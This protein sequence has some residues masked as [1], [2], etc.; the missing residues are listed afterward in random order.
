MQRAHAPRSTL[1]LIP[2]SAF[3]QRCRTASPLQFALSL[4][5][6]IEGPHFCCFKLY[7][8]NSPESYNS[9]K[10]TKVLRDRSTTVMSGNCFNSRHFA[11]H[12][13][14]P[15]WTY[16]HIGICFVLASASITHGCVGRETGQFARRRFRCHK[17][18]VCVRGLG[19]R[20]TPRRIGTHQFPIIEANC[21]G[22]RWRHPLQPMNNRKQKW[23]PS[24]HPHVTM[25][26]I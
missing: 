2:L 10:K 23:P 24:T 3:L 19:R 22:L 1:C 13:A 7:E 26:K 21:A 18:P 8:N 5:I 11:T 17:Q 14:F 15:E 16:V 12:C 20:V 6:V 9:C 4:D 25:H